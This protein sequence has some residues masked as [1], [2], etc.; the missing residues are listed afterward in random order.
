MKPVFQPRSRI[1]LMALAACYPVIGYGAGTVRLDFVV[2]SVVAVAPSGTQRPLAKGAD[3]FSG[4]TIR[5]GPDGRAQLRFD[6]GAMVSLQPQSEFRLDNYQFS[7][8]QNGQ[9]KGFF[10]LLKGGFRTLTGIVGRSN[11]ESYKVT[12]AVAT[13]G[14]RGTEYTISYLDSNAIS[15]SNGEGS[16]EV[17]NGAGCVILRSGDSAIV[18]GPNSPLRLTDTRPRLDPPQIP[19][20]LLAT[21][22]TS[23]ARNPDGS[24]AIAPQMVSGPGYTMAFAGHDATFD[25]TLTPGTR[26]GFTANF[27]AS[28]VMISGTGAGSTFS[29]G[30][31]AGGFS[32]DGVIGWGRWSSGT[33]TYVSGSSSLID[34]QN[35]HYAV[36]KTTSA[37]ELTSLAGVTATYNLIGYT[38]PTATN[39][40]L[41]GAPTG[42][43]TASFNVTQMSVSLN[44]SIP[45]ASNTYVISGGTGSTSLG[46][47]FSFSGISPTYSVAG[48]F[49]GSNASHAGVT[50]KVEIGAGADLS[51]AA[52]FKR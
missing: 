7:G 26:D 22:S 49:A 12:T 16:I 8:V 51:G 24:L 35:L 37:G 14:I 2:G 50:Y 31:V 19:Q 25:A 20:L 43:L 29:A 17:C 10:S 11:K 5:T 36:G 30:N 52:A 45:Y 47:S 28:S 40:S 13:I 6:D 27:D 46:S 39:G 32:A 21:F 9:E 44:M 15:I 18:E 33:A 4:E 34:V 48:F 23:E 3:V 38:L 42:T 41:G 1:V